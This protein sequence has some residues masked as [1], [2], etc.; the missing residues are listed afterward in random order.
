V[1]EGAPRCGVPSQSRRYGHF[2]L[3]ATQSFVQARQRSP[4][5]LSTSLAPRLPRPSDLIH[6]RLVDRRLAYKNMRTALIAGAISL[7]V[8]ALAW[9]VGLIY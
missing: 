3:S 5:S 1:V 9:V 7:I 6:L 8:F 2:R 4:A